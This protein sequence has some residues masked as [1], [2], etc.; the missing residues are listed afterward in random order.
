VDLTGAR[1][2]RF[3]R[4]RAAKACFADSTR[5]VKNSP[6]I[7]ARRAQMTWAMNSTRLVLTPE[8]CAALPDNLPAGR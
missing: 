5:A 6:A 2:D 3:E 4:D 7:E 8:R 1:P